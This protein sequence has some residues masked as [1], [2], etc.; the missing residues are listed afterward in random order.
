MEVR[1]QH[2]KVNPEAYQTMQKLEGFIKSSGLE[3]T[4]YELIKIR[5]SQINGCA[6]CLD[7]HTRELK[8]MGETDQRINLI[9]VWHESL[10][11]SDR[12]KAALELT[13][14]VTRI[15]DKGVPNDVYARVR[16]QF[17]EKEYVTLIMAINTINSWNRI[18]ISTGMFPGCM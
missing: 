10:I 17:T 11:Y 14:Y 2:G 18:A 7:M 4:L 6:F 12:E 16:E 5:A 9:S 13:E 1:I 8:E 15:A 3:R